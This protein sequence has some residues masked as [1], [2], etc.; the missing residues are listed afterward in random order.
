[1]KGLETLKKW[2]GAITE[3]GLLLV[4]L[5]IV[6]TILFG[7]NI[8]FFP[9]DVVGNLIQLIQDLGNSGLVGLIALAV[10]L[11]LFSNRKVS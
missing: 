4:A 7:K 11:W 10:I 2:T 1:M 3:L 8:P 5:A 9:S 6:I